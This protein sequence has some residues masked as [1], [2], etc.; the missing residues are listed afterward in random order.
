M[1]STTRENDTTVDS[2]SSTDPEDEQYQAQRT[3]EVFEGIP[4]I[5]E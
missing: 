1:S 5:I 3:G 2:E 4:F